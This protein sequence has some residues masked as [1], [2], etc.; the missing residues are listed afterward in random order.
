MADL[1]KRESLYDRHRRGH[2][3]T[4]IGVESE[5]ILLIGELE[6]RTDEYEGRCRLAAESEANY[7][8][9]WAFA[10]IKAEGTE[11][12]RKAQADAECHEDR[13]AA[14]VAE[15]LERSCKERMVSLR[16]EVSALQSLLSSVRNQ[17]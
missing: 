17:T 7:K 6:E 5:I 11:Q 16:H 10:F 3:L 12:R 14:Q 13:F 8:A 15:G 1:G 2:P 9:K 4:T